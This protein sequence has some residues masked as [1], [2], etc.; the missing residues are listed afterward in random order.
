MTE[1]ILLLL[2]IALCTYH[3]VLGELLLPSKCP[4]MEFKG[5]KTAASIQIYGH[6]ILGNMSAHMC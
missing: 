6:Y 3:S 1:S 4:C 2:K 5:V